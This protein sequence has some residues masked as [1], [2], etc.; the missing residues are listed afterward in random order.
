MIEFEHFDRRRFEYWTYLSV[1]NNKTLHLININ[2][3][4]LRTLCG[5]Y[6]GHYRNVEFYSR[7]NDKIKDYH[8]C[9]RCRRSADPKPKTP[10][11]KKP[12]REVHHIVRRIGHEDAVEN[13]LAITGYNADHYISMW[14]NKG[15][16]LHSTHLIRAVDLKEFKYP[17]RWEFWKT[18]ELV[19]DYGVAFEVMWV[20]VK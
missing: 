17:R 12:E 1:G 11:T 5:M 13:A 8:L 6:H 10:R 20:L 3:P 4:E 15:F 7:P 16:E 19:N 18:P 14:L 2:P 9:V